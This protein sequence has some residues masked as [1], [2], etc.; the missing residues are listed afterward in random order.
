MYY[1]LYGN[2]KE[3][4]VLF[5]H[6]GPGSGFHDKH[7]VFFNSKKHNVIFF[8]QRGSGKSTPFASI[9]NNTTQDLVSD[10]KKL[11]DYLGFNKVFLFGGSWGSTMALLFAIEYP[12]MV[13]GMFLR[14]I[15]L[16]THKE[17]Y[18]YY[19]GG[20][21]KTYFPEVWERFVS[22]VPKEKRS[23]MVK[24]YLEK[25]HSKDEEEREKYLYE[26]SFYESS[27]MTLKFDPEG[28]IKE[29]KRDKSYRSLSPLEA[30]YM[31]NNCFLEEDFILKNIKK[32]PN[33]PIT[34]V[35][36]R[37][38]MVCPPITAYNLYKSLP[39]SKLYLV[40][41]GHHGSDLAIK[42]KTIEEMEK[43]NA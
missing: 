18:E 42:K 33:V 35:Q 19:L 21:V 31:L 29:F 3:I 17:I 9:R 12:Q 30:H 5:F 23:E 7:K 41:A 37:Y 39:S 36:G 34:I 32:I 1:E 28:L 16:A 22:L 10:S 38:D 4:P 8:D 11:L 20:N 14:G 2:P 6:G 25:M 13:T 24:F 15:F 40:T 27:I 26:W 43:I